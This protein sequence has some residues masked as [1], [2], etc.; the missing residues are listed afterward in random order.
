[1]GTVLGNRSEVRDVH[2]KPDFGSVQLVVGGDSRSV[3]ADSKAFP[4][5]STLRG[6]IMA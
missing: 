1:V 6:L 5:E 3:Q 4:N 2:F